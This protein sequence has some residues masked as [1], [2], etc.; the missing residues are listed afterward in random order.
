VGGG[1]NVVQTYTGIGFAQNTS[2]G[3]GQVL[4]FYIN[5]GTFGVIGGFLI[6][7]GLMGWLDLRMCQSLT[8][9]D[10]KGF[11]RNYMICL[12]LIQPG[13]NLVEVSVSVLGSAIT[14]GIIAAFVLPRVGRDNSVRFAEGHVGSVYFTSIPGEPTPKLQRLSGSEKPRIGRI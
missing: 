14:S 2:V 9:N 11:L 13:G 8:A 4:E 12:A 1:G 5:F 3:A 6:W 10:Q 7:G